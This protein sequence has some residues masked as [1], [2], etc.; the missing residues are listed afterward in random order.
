MNK[1]IDMILHCPKC[2]VQHID[3]REIAPVKNGP[4]NGPGD[5]GFGIRVVWDNPPHRSHLCHSCGCVWR[6]A[7][8]CTN[9]VAQIE[10]RGKDD[11]WPAI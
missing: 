11:N 3:R 8:V 10:T 9:G 5:R 1:P 4:D 2:H 7:D 6:P